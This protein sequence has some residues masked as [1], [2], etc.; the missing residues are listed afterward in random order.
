MGHYAVLRQVLLVPCNQRTERLA[1]VVADGDKLE[2][3]NAMV[4]CVDKL[5]LQNLP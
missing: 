5:R 1:A 4:N 2:E 3:T